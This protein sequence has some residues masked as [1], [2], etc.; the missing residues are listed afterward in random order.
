MLLIQDTIQQDFAE[1]YADS[2]RAS[3]SQTPEHLTLLLRAAARLLA[4]D[5]A[6]GSNVPREMPVAHTALVILHIPVLLLPLI[7]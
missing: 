3:S 2:L 4:D 5:D 7:D 1:K 6:S